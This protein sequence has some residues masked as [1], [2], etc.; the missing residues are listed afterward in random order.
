MLSAVVMV[1]SSVV[2]G[3]RVKG[4]RNLIQDLRKQ[5]IEKKRLAKSGGGGALKLGVRKVD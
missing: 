4:V 2:F 3:S 5:E 1:L